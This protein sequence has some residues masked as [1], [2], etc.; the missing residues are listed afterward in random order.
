M[1][2]D[3]IYTLISNWHLSW[4][5]LW[6]SYGTL[7]VIYSMLFLL[8]SGG[9]KRITNEYFRDPVGAFLW[10]YLVLGPISGA[11]VLI[12]RLGISTQNNLQAIGQ[13]YSDYSLNISN[14]TVFF[15]LALIISTI[16]GVEGVIR[17]R[18]H[19]NKLWLNHPKIM[20]PIM[21][22]IFNIPMGMMIIISIVRLLDQWTT[23]HLFLN[24]GWL[25]LS[26]YQI[27][28]LYGLRWLYKII[29]SQITLAIVASFGS[30]IML[31]RE[32]KQEYFW[33]YKA[34]FWISIIIIICI[35]LIL[36]NDLNAMISAIHNTLT[37]NFI[38]RIDITTP[39]LSKPDITLLLQ[40]I[41][42]TNHLNNLITLPSS[43]PTPAWLSGLIGIRL[44][45]FFIE[46]YRIIG[47]HLGWKKMPKQITDFIKILT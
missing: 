28:N 7:F 1:V 35:A 41:L 14:N 20:H 8:F 43:I 16:C 25:P 32:G 5:L 2:Y 6:L 27:D 45:I 4:W 30:L 34:S 26:P 11:Y 31:V 47:K 19:R 40:Q 13:I 9:K 17:Y 36:A 15:W 12:A 42:L 22:I 3:P 18:K 46:V 33:R 23:I 10:P 24:S 21:V 29:I 44:V 37:A 39:F 38:F